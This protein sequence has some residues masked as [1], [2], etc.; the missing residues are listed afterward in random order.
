MK[1]S[2]KLLTAFAA[3]AVVASIA[4][5]LALAG[6]TQTGGTKV[7]LANSKLGHILVDSKGITLYDFVK[8]KGTTS[9][10]YGA[11]AA[12][13]P[14]LITNGKPVAGPRRPR[15]AA[16]HDEAQGRQARGHLRRSPALLLRDRP[17]AGPD[18]RPGRQP[19]RRPVVGPLGRGQGDPPWL[20]HRVTPRT[21]GA[22]HGCRARPNRRDE[23]RG[24]DRPLPRRR[25]DPARRRRPRPAVLRRVLL[26]RADDRHALPAQLRR[27]R[28]RRRRADRSGAAARPALGDLILVAG[29]ARR[30]RD[31]TR[32]ARQPADQRVH[33]ALRLHGVRLPAR[34]RP[35]AASSTA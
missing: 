34:D 25:L 2:L 24:R 20:A 3:S 31:R 21:A 16:R 9:A 17:Q 29:R 19:V 33:A 10:C 5:A 28:R 18:D 6:G 4:A 35:H 32:L 30:D 7:A 11:C 1:R 26:G 13:W 12:L 8:D 23:R 15:F 22:S 27:R 14:P